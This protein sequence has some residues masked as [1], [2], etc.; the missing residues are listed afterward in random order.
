M[1]WI[2]KGFMNIMWPFVDANTKKKVR[3]E[4]DIAAAGDIAKDELLRECGG[5][6][7]VS[8]P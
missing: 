6:L 1:P 5:D 4:M 3:I 8:P 2:V 7:E